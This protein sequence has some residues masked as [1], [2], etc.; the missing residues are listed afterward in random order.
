MLSL[1]F[2]GLKHDK[3]VPFNTTFLALKQDYFTS[4]RYT[5]S[6]WLGLIILSQGLINSSKHFHYD[7]I[8]PKYDV[9]RPN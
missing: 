8:M 1:Q 4:C 3:K 7:V 5:I 6:I 2:L 9:I